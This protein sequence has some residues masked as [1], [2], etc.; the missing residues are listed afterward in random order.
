MTNYVYKCKRMFFFFGY[1][2]INLLIFLMKEIDHFDNS[3][4]LLNSLSI[5]KIHVSRSFSCTAP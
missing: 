1:L 3:H 2:K 5:F 4:C